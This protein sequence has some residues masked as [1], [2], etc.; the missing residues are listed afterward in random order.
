MCV[1]SNRTP[2]T[3]PKSVLSPRQAPHAAE[4]NIHILS[5]PLL[6]SPLLSSLLLSSPLLYYTILYYTTLYYTILD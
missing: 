4:S 2:P 5:F 1:V 3:S 6:S